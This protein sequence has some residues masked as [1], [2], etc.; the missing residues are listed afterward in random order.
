M[1]EARRGASRDGA[2]EM[3]ARNGGEVAE[4]AEFDTLRREVDT[5]RRE[6]LRRRGRWRAFPAASSLQYG[7]AHSTPRCVSWCRPQD[8]T[9]ECLES[10]GMEWALKSPMDFG[11]AAPHVAAEAARDTGSDKDQA[12]LFETTLSMGWGGRTPKTAAPSS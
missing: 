3:L 11:S 10:R 12:D 9:G 6:R 8:V 1:L 7:I 2:P 5:L 4:V